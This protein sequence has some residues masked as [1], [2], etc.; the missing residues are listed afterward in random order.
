[1]STDYIQDSLID[2]VKERNHK[3]ETQEQY[4]GANLS[5]TNIVKI[6]PLYESYG[7]LSPISQKESILK[8]K[9][10]EE[11]K[12]KEEILLNAKYAIYGTLIHNLEYFT[13]IFQQRSEITLDYLETVFPRQKIKK[14][15]EKE[16]KDDNYYYSLL[17]IQELANQEYGYSEDPFDNALNFWNTW[18]LNGQD[19]KPKGKDGALLNALDIKNIWE[20]DVVPIGHIEIFRDNFKEKYQNTNSQNIY[21][22]MFGRNINFNQ[23]NLK[24]TCFVDKLSIPAN[25]PDNP[26]KIID[27][28]TGKQFK[29]PTKAEKLQI[30]LITVCAYSNLIDHI[31]KKVSSKKIWDIVHDTPNSNY[32]RILNNDL[33][34]NKKSMYTPLWYEDIAQF[35]DNLSQKTIFSYINPLTQDEIKI[36]LKKDLGLNNYGNIITLLKYIE[37]I[38]EFYILNKKELETIVNTKNPAFLLP[39]FPIKDF[40]KD[41]Y[42]TK[43]IAVQKNFL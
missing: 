14:N 16:N 31:D 34:S 6:I 10:K 7:H 8:Y 32:L 38:N 25:Y 22:R 2:T 18:R 39:K 24:T 5:P 3:E 17:K 37:K 13:E 42:K 35:Y 21:E 20:D 4:L 28:K 43:E 29:Y 40:Y 30:F 41:D 12:T 19:F 36:D 9:Q 11:E 26:I 1:M 33:L 23:A 27:F 15:K